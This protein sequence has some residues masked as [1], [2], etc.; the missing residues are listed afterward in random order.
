MSPKIFYGRKIFTHTLPMLIVAI[1]FCGSELMGQFQISNMIG[2]N[3]GFGYGA[4]GSEALS[5]RLAMA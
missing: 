4:S 3:D 1:F 5:P 2:D